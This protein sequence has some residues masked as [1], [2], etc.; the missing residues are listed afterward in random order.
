[1][2]TIT[3]PEF[4]RALGV[5]RSEAAK[6]LGVA[7]QTLYNWLERHDGAIPDPW[8]WKAQ[9]LIQAARTAGTGAL[10]KGA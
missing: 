3:V 8:S 6:R 7:R 10:E 4:E 9:S 5:S 1:M 2:S